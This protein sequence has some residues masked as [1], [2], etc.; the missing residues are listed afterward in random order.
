[1]TGIEPAYPAWKS[2]RRPAGFVPVWWFLGEQEK[3]FR[4]D[5]P[6]LS[7]SLTG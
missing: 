5:L 3:E 2:I 6:H 1:M 7:Q 4:A